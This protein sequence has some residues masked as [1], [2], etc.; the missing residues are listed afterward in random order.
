MPADGRARDQGLWT[1][2]RVADR[3]V[4]WVSSLPVVG[5]YRAADSRSGRHAR[6]RGSEEGRKPQA[7]GLL[8]PVLGVLRPLRYLEG[9]PAMNVTGL[10]RERGPERL[11]RRRRGCPRSSSWSARAARTR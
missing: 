6:P 8:D 3:L 11:E 7:K 1:G 5:S 9:S 4:A 2:F 10:A